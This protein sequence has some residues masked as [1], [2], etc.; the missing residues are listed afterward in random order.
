[1][2]IPR[3]LITLLVAIGLTL[4]LLASLALA[5]SNNIIVTLTAPEWMQDTFT[6]ELLAEFEAQNPGVD[7]VFV[8]SGDQMY[9]G[10]AAYDPDA[11]FENAS[12][13][14][15]TA[16]VLYVEHYTLSPESTRAGTLLDLSPLTSSDPSLNQ[17]DF[18][19]AAWES[20]QWDG[21]VWALPVSMSLNVLIYNQTRFDELGL[22]YPNEAWTMDDF[23]NAMRAL[24][25]TD[26]SGE[27]VMPGYV[28]WGTSGILF[29][30]LLGHGVYDDSV[31][32]NAVNLQDP[33]LEQL[34][35]TWSELSAE[36]YTGQ[37]FSGS[38]QDIPLRIEGLYALSSGFVL[39]SESENDVWAASLLPGGVA[40][41]RAQG[42]A[43]SAGTQYP[44]QAY[45]LVK[46]LTNNAEVSSR[47][48]GDT[49]ARRSLVGVESEDGPQFL[50]ELPEEAEALRD[51]ALEVALPASELRFMDY[52][53]IALNSM[54]PQ[55]D[56]L[57]AASALQQAQDTANEALQTADEWRN[58]ASVVVMQPTPTPVLSAGEIALRFQYTAFIS[59]L[60]NREAWEEA[61]QEFVA[62]D[63]E[64]GQVEFITNFGSE[65]EDIDCYVQPYNAVPSMDLTTVLN[66]DPYLNADPSFDRNDFLG[67]VLE[68]VSRE[69]MTWAIPLYVQP[70]ILWYNS[71][72]F[73]EMGAQLPEDGWT[74]DQFIDALQMLRPDPEGQAPFMPGGSGGTYVLLLTAAFGGL[75]L[76]YR[77]D[78]PTVSF[79]DPANVDAI[80]QVLD[81]AKEGYIH[82]NELGNLM[83][84]GGFSSSEQAIYNETLS[85]FSWRLTASSDDFPSDYVDPYRLT[86]FPRGTQFSGISYDIGAGYINAEAVNP[87]A[88]YRWL[89]F[90]SGHSDL[91]SAMPARRSG[92]SALESGLVTDAD[93]SAVFNEIDALLQDPSTFVMPS[94]FTGGGSVSGYLLPVWLNRAFDAYVLEDADLQTELD[95]AQ[96]TATTYLECVSGIEERPLGELTAMTQD[97]QIAY[98]RQFTDCAVSVDPSLESIFSFPED[99]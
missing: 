46:F 37:S 84:G 12:E 74:V 41:V 33:E 2:R 66:L 67:G 43:I 34:L 42:F 92:L 56:N 36:G 23:A 97:E 32:P 83:G 10:S 57:D 68:Q 9:F 90:L 54:D 40:G 8:L 61:I 51:Q 76:D 27:V 59:P 63:P 50:M 39:G 58:S 31:I 62:A 95:E 98:A 48:F 72:T 85:A 14:A 15:Q 89:S 26:S 82:Y 65:Q 52:V 94:Q 22:S 71:E 78:P 17:E 47:F 11:F 16:D 38:S 19:P 77:T 18:F 4:P 44:E 7:A 45:A 64:V 29:R 81:L 49:P 96:M 1:M 28:D 69:N 80:R 88:C 53:N 21:G 55:M 79:N 25:E 70:E 91:F 86:T 60:P 5:Q 6:D 24:A 75:P 93:L 3:Y 87:D 35:T 73:S 20:F 13:Y 99:E 30:A